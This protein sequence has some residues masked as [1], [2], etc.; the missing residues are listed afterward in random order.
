[1]SGLRAK[2]YFVAVAPVLAGEFD[3]RAEQKDRH[4]DDG[5]DEKSDLNSL[6][7]VRFSAVH[8]GGDAIGLRRGRLL[9][10]V[11]EE[12]HVDE[13]DEDGWSAVGLLVTYL[14]VEVHPGVLSI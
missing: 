8:E 2:F 13:G 9:F 7:Q 14:D 11:T 12:H 10:A 1:M 3:W 4:I 5:D 6:L